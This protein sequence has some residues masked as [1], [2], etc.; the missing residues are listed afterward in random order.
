MLNPESGMGNFGL[1]E[2]RVLKAQLY[3]RVKSEDDVRCKTNHCPFLEDRNFP[4]GKLPRRNVVFGSEPGAEAESG[5]STCIV[6]TEERVPLLPRLRG[7]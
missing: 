2:Q 3:P 1:A 6:D 5:P 7:A 4:E